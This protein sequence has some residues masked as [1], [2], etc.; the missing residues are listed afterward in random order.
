MVT[1]LAVG[2]AYAV[3]TS[4]TKEVSFQ[5]QS[6]RSLS[7]NTIKLCLALLVKPGRHLLL[8]VLW[9]NSAPVQV[10]RLYFVISIFQF[11][12]MRVTLAYPT[13]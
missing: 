3:I 11:T 1:I 13:Q 10:F 8:T 6:A 12:V 9:I 2:E 5:Y 4:G 7:N